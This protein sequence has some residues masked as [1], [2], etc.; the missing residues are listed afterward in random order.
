MPVTTALPQDTDTS[1]NALLDAFYRAGHLVAAR[2]RSAPGPVRLSGALTEL[3]FPEWAIA[4]VAE[5]V[6]FD[7]DRPDVL[8]SDLP[9]QFVGEISISQP[10]DVHAIPRA[11]PASRWWRRESLR[12]RRMT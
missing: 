4:E 11:L 8:P 5:V 12:P 3:G 1:A 10:A 9:G 7:E 2:R 6:A